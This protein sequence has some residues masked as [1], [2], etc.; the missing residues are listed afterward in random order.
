MK[1]LSKTIGLFMFSHGG[2]WNQQEECVPLMWCV[3]L[4]SGLVALL[5]GWAELGRNP[6]TLKILAR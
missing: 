6:L 1:A 2:N 5:C 3:A 4:C